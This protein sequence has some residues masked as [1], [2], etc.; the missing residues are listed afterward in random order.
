MLLHDR[1]QQ[2]AARHPGKTALKAGGA[3]WSYG[4]LA[5]ASGCLAR[6]LVREGLQR[7]DRVVL[8]MDNSAD[9][10]L[11]IFAVLEAGGVFVCLNP[12]TK[13][14]KLIYVLRDCAARVLIT[15]S[16]R[17]LDLVQVRA[18]APSLQ[19]V[20]VDRPEAAPGSTASLAAILA[21][22]PLAATLPRI[23]DIDLA[24]LIYT[25]GSTGNPKGVM[26]SH[27]NMHSAVTSITTYLQNT[28]EDRV[29]CVLPLSFDYGL[30]Q[31]LM[32]LSFGGTLILE[33][34]FAWPTMIIQRLLE[35]KVT[36]FPGVPTLFA[37]LLNA[38]ILE[39]YTFPHLRYISNTAAALPT[40]LISRLRAALPGVTL[41][42]M[43]GLTECKRVAYLPPEELDRRPHSVGKAMPNCETFVVDEHGQP[44]PP[45]EVGELVVRGANVMQGYWNLPEETAR[46]LR[47]G[48]HPYERVLYSGDLFKQDE[49]GFL[50]FVGRKDDI[51]KCRGEKVSPREVENVL[52]QIEGIEEAAVLGR[53]DPM[54]GE[55]VTAVVKRSGKGALEAAEVLRYCAG[56][57]ESYC[58]PQEVLFIAEMPKSSNGKIDKKRIA[59]AL[60]AGGLDLALQAEPPPA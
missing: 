16:A 45:G 15:Q 38:Q 33:K 35:E 28:P 4:E 2:N 50:Y 41:F 51:I 34:D 26:M 57:L 56:K 36:G 17:H 54:L 25:S 1:F 44:V 20:L 47:P 37:V 9:L 21:A 48:R 19:I 8:Y 22:P 27:L 31:L 12:T 59:A 53:P 10:C 6:A 55:A 3:A 40:A 5:A 46:A 49:E 52:Y 29:L 14:D 43:Y 30:Y 32:V 39:K 11:A 23:I 42:S 18:D 13:Y 60:A 58:V 24:A 7:G